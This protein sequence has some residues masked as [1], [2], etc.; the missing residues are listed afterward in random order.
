MSGMPPIRSQNVLIVD[1]E[2]RT[3]E[4]LATLLREDGFNVEVLYDGGSAMARL[5]RAPALDA[6]VTELSLPVADG[7]ALSRFA[8]SRDPATN[9]IVLTRHPNLLDASRFG[10][11]APVVLT[12]PL[13]YARLL[14][15]LGGVSLAG[16]CLA[17]PG[18]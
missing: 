2:A 11:R 13:D 17:S 3:S 8:R 1:G 12:K 14:E 16:A 6:V 9:I 10:D 4:R 18:F 5:A 15:A 7:A